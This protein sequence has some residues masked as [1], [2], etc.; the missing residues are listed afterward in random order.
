MV[1]I[2]TLLLLLLHVTGPSL[3]FENLCPANED[4]DPCYCVSDG[5]TIR[6]DCMQVTDAQ[7]V[8][9]AL[10]SVKGIKR[11]FIDFLRARLDAV[12]SDLFQGLH[13][14]KLS[15]T[16]CKLKTLGDEGRSALEG[17]EDIIEVRGRN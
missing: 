16:N 11:V 4:L 17:L 1:P 6:V 12:P 7:E 8:H 14:S 2:A 3:G 9:K 5:K 13:I 10:Q 15:F